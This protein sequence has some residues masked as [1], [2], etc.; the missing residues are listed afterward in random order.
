MNIYLECLV[1]IVYIVIFAIIIIII[2]IEIILWYYAYYIIPYLRTKELDNFINYII[3]LKISGLVDENSILSA[4]YV[5]DKDINVL[6]KKI[7]DL[8]ENDK[9]IY[10]KYKKLSQ[11]SKEYDN[12]KKMIHSYT[13]PKSPI[14]LSDPRDNR[15]LIEGLISL[16][17]LSVIYILK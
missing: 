3:N 11:I 8:S 1:Y 2:F 4:A 9:I 12:Q 16:G 15:Y 14:Y 13:I 5:L 7:D 10:N 17:F 6:E